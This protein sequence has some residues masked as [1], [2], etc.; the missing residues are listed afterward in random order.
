MFRLQVSGETL[1]NFGSAIEQGRMVLAQELCN[2]I[3]CHSTT[4]EYRLTQ[5]CYWKFVVYERRCG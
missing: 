2:L 1:A 5:N 4:G 3:V